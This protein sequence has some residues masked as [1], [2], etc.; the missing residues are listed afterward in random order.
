MFFTLCVDHQTDINDPD[1]CVLALKQCR[2]LIMLNMQQFQ[3]F[4]RKLYDISRS[5]RFMEFIDA[6]IMEACFRHLSI[7]NPI[8]QVS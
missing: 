5:T 3:T 8:A 1:G 4:R 6:G 7:A 2:E